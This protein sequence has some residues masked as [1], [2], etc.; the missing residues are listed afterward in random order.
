MS[1]A[2]APVL[3]PEIHAGAGTGVAMFE[4]TKLDN[5]IQLRKGG[6]SRWVVHSSLASA[7]VKDLG[8]PMS[9]LDGRQRRVL[10]VAMT[11]ALLLLPW[12]AAAFA[13]QPTLR[14]PLLDKMLGK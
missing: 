6:R 13:Q 14:D 10:I 3:V 12:A 5:A 7:C 11:W 8:G 1:P 9:N 4:V 2:R